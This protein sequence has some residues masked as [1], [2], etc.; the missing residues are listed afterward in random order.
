[1]IHAYDERYVDDAM[2]N[3]G[4]AVDYAVNVCGFDMDTFMNIFIVSGLA[5]Q[6]GGGVPKYVS[7]TSG[8]ELVYEVMTKSGIDVV[9]GDAQIEYEYSVEY[10]SGWIIAYYQWYTGRSFKYIMQ[11][12]SMKEIERLYSTL[13]EASED[14]CVDVINQLISRNS[15]TTRLQSYRKVL[16]YSQRELAEKSGV[17][18][19]AIQQY[20]QRAKDINRASAGALL[21][22]GRTLGCRVEDLLE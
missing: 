13:H 16:G 22:L 1:M 5:V 15:L 12:I 18:L 3:L 20:E 19:R 11:N 7:G 6:F 8:T 21:A 10:W 17:S 14:K 9:I 4:E 2:S